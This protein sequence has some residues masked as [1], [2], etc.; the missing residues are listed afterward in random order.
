MKSPAKSFVKI[1]NAN[2]QFMSYYE[3]ISQ[4]QKD[5][6]RVPIWYYIALQ[7]WAL[8]RWFV[9]IANIVVIFQVHDLT[10]HQL[11]QQLDFLITNSNRAM[12]RKWGR[13]ANPEPATIT[14]PKPE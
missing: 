12:K 1:R 2:T 4:K 11:N 10:I 14:E 7:Y 3:R 8:R 6:K 9:S 13:M 5:K